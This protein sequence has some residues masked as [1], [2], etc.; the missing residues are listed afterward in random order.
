LIKLKREGGR[1]EKLHK[2]RDKRYIREKEDE[3]KEIEKKYIIQIVYKRQTIFKRNNFK[4][5][6]DQTNTTI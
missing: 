1:K 6:L 5:R 3:R 2:E 4:G